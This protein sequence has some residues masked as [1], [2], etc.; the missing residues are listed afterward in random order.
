[1][2]RLPYARKILIVDDEVDITTAFKLGLEEAVQILGQIT[3]PT[4]LLWGRQSF[5]RD[6][7]VDPQAA[8]IRSKK[9]VKVDHAGHWLHHDQLALFLRETKTFLAA[10][11]RE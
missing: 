3:C 8:A 9:I 4:L 11:A 1:M 5:A 6:P 2:S 10:N 7:D